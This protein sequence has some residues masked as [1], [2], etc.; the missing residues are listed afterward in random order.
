MPPLSSV[1]LKPNW[2]TDKHYTS[3]AVTN[4]NL[5]KAIST[6]LIEN[7]VKKI[8][9]A[10]SAMIGKKTSDVINI[11]NVSELSSHRIEVADLKQKGYTRIVIP[12]ALKYRRMWVSDLVINSDIIINVPVLKTHDAFPCSIG[13][14]NMKGV[15]SDNEKKKLHLMGLDEG[16][17]DINKVALPD[18]TVIDGSV[19]MEGDGPVNG[20]PVNLNLLIASDNA[21]AAEVVAIRIMGLDET[22]M[23]YIEMAYDAGF[24][25]MN[26]QNITIVGENL[27]QMIHPFKTSYYCEQK[28]KNKKLIICDENACSGCRDTL[29]QFMHNKN[30]REDVNKIKII[31]GRYDGIYRDEH[32]QYTIGLGRCLYEHKDRFDKYIP[33]CAPLKINLEKAYQELVKEE[34][35][36]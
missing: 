30:F 33:G 22:K 19:G 10:D 27:V 6:H 14:K 3:G 20:T 7:M 18:F 8:T 5:L 36:E 29:V 25:E 13:L 16:I 24:G 9:I 32:D 28:L 21:L 26:L 35:K 31:C 17:I 12:N 2:V 34:N 1:M 15:I 11:N 23:K 4:T